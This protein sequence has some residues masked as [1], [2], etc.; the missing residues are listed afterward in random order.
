M[1]KR[2]ILSLLTASA[3]SASALA[4]EVAVWRL[5]VADH[6]EAVVRA[7]DLDSGETLARVT[8]ESPASL[9]AGSDG[10]AVFAVQ[11]EAD[12]VSAIRTGIALEDHGDHG[13]L[14][15]GDPAPVEAVLTGARPV[16]FV[17]HGGD[18]AVFFDGDGT[19]SVVGVRAWVEDGTA[20]PRRTEDSGAA[21][22]GVAVPW[23]EHLI[24]SV[25]HP[26]DPSNLPVGVEVRDAAG[27]RV[28]DVHD[29]PDL[30]GEASSG[31]L[32]AIACADGL[33]VVSGSGAPRIEHVGYDGLPEGKATTLAGGVGLQYFLSNF[34]AD[35]VAVLD[36]SGEGHLLIDLPTRR[37]AFAVDP[38]RARFA[39]VFTEDGQLHR[40]DVVAGEITASV[41]VTGPYSMDGA[42]SLP[43]PRI[44]VAGDVVA[45]TDPLEA[46]VHLVD[47]A[48]FAVSGG[49]DVEGVPFGIV[50]VGG[51]G[52]VH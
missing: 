16:H 45:V 44:A 22:H 43:R 21:H 6:A 7:I 23:G 18:V 11:G 46:R 51:S 31:N 29:C 17:E 12:R 24:V 28:G 47:V 52:T 32:L 3:L 14:S 2:L 50:A 40:I 42:W 39:Y 4:D 19:V 8:L 10:T 27:Q 1:Q 20:E 33:L 30:H 37:V 35:R 41:A 15:I 34:G 5:F 48:D 13:D 26:E 9:H 49:I 25:P 36:P 38:V